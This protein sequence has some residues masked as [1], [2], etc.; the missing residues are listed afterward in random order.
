MSHGG[1]QARTQYRPNARLELCIP[2]CPVDCIAMVTTVHGIT[3]QARA[4][5]ARSRYLARRSRLE[6]QGMERAS[7]LA[8]ARDETAERR[9][10]ATIARVM[11]R[12]RERLQQRRTKPE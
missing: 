9:K 6:R 3:R 7:N 11:Q 12:A 2:P 4:G 5:H 10:R 8:A 1:H